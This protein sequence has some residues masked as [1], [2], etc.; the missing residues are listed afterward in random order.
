MREFERTRSA[1]KTKLS[2]LLRDQPETGSSLSRIQPMLHQANNSYVWCLDGVNPPPWIHRDVKNPDLLKLHQDLSSQFLSNESLRLMLLDYH[3]A[4]RNVD[5]WK[6]NN[7]PTGTWKV[8]H[9]M[10]QGVWQGDRT[11]YCPN[12]MQLLGKVLPQLMVNNVYGNVLLSVLE[13]GSSIEPHF[14]PCNY[15]LRCH[16]PI[17]PSTGFCI[18]V[19]TEIHS[20]EEGKILLFSDHHEHEVWHIQQAG[21]KPGSR[22]VLI[23]DIWHPSITSEEKLILNQLFIDS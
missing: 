15:R 8:Y 23:M 7:V 2:N 6:I 20:W 9:L 1:L 11:S 14:G 22:V 17:F 3:Q 16:I 21:N 18:R 12:I 4:E 5:Q 10:D 13:P 19:G